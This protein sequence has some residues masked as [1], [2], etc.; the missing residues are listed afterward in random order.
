[1]NISNK[2]TNIFAIVLLSIMFIVGLASYK[3]DALTMDEQSHIGAGYSYLSQQDFRINPEHPPLIK[4][5]SAI[6]L[7]FLDL[8][9]P[10]EDAAWTEGINNQW[11]FGNKFIFNSGNNADQLIF[12]ARLPMLLVLLSLGWFLFWWTK[13]EFGKEVSLITL[14]LFSFSPSF[15]AHGRLVTTDIG[16]VLGFVLSTYFWLKFLRNPSTKNVIYAGL[17]F[18]F[19]MLLKFSLAL[20]VPFF[21]IVTL[22]YVLIKKEN[23]IQYLGKSILIGLIGLIF[24]IWPVYQVHVTNYP[25]ERQVIDTTSMLQPTMMNPLRELLISMANIPI[26]R[27][28]GLYFTGLLMAT[29]RTAFGNTTYFLGKMANWSYRSYFPVIY[30]LKIPVAFH[31]LTLTTLLLLISQK[32]KKDQATIKEKIESHFTEF[33]MLVFLLI[34]WSTSIL[35]NLNLGIRHLLPVFPF[36]YILVSLYLVGFIEKIKKPTLKKASISFISLCLVWYAGSSLINYP[37]Y[38]SYFNEIV[39]TDNGYKYVVD[40]NYDW[41]QDFK[42]LVEWVDENNIDKIKIDYFGGAD[43]NYYLEDKAVWFDS[44]SGIQKG[45]VAVSTTYLQSG[46]GE[47]LPGF[48]SY[49]AGFYRWLEDYKPIARAGKSIL[50]YYIE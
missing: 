13:K 48:T 31:I 44:S 14:F 22:V 25:A 18:G 11:I 2:L 6:P 43:V 12:W 10:V 37:Y 15:I 41:G 47:P 19:S 24:V 32:F 29:Q 17:I 20:L 4:D 40:S 42:R 30:L 39:G 5:L 46:I 1:M 45:F 34:Y 27:S 16:A 21:G 35:G 33:S 23:L 3:Q 26:I 50:I 9:F 8:N 38:I 7:L 36:T 28:I 49:N